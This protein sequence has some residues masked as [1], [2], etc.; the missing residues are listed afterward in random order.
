MGM[1]GPEFNCSYAGNF[2]WEHVRDVLYGKHNIPSSL[3]F[4]KHFEKKTSPVG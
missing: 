1:L 2:E 4:L 3:C